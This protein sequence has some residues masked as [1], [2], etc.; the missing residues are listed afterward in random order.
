[1]SK[2]THELMQRA[3][4]VR[5]AELP[6]GGETGELW[7]EGRAVVFEE[8]TVLWSEGEIDYTEQIARS[9]FTD[10]LMEDVIFNYNHGGKVLARTRN[11]TL[12]LDIRED[13][14]YCSTLR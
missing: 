13:G 14:L 8:P 4:H 10:C 1:M 12:E 11:H 5:A 6:E 7:V 3:F 9:A 2:R